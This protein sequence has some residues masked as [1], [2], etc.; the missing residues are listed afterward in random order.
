LRQS[1]AGSAGNLDAILDGS[2][3]IAL[4]ASTANPLTGQPPPGVALHSLVS[5][6][7]VSSAD[8]II[9]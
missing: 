1:S 8:R 7:L 4:T 6:P 5:E 3:D 2:M 9:D